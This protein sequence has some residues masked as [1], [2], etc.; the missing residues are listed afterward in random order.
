V[1]AVCQQRTLRVWN[2]SAKLSVPGGPA[3]NSAPLHPRLHFSVDFDCS[4]SVQ[5]IRIDK[6]IQ[7]VPVM[8]AD[9]NMNRADADLTSPDGNDLSD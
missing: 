8:F 1:T 2:S 4:E 3:V 5:N 7:I 9:G 6:P